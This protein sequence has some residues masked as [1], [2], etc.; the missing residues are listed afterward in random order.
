[1]WKPTCQH[2]VPRCL[3]TAN[4]TAR[5]C[6]HQVSVCSMMHRPQGSGAATGD[7]ADGIGVVISQK[8]AGA[9]PWF[10]EDDGG[11]GCLTGEGEFFQMFIIKN[12]RHS[13]LQ[14]IMDTLYP[15]TQFQQ[16]S[17]QVSVLFPLYYHS[18]T[19]NYSEAIPILNN[20]LALNILTTHE[21]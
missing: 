9:R 12:G 3:D 14:S 13:K 19:F 2:H 11:R 6:S 20:I 7:A 5:S 10:G 21:V 4:C 15:F 18:L 17:T 8:A 16:L 1:M